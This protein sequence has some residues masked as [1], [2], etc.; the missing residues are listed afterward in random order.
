MGAILLFSGYGEAIEIKEA[1]FGFNEVRY[2]GGNKEA[3]NKIALTFDDAPNGATGDILRILKERKIKAT[4]F[5][6]GSQ[7]KKYP[8]MAR[9]IV[10]QGHEIGN[11]SYSH[12][13]D[14]SFTLEAILEDLKR[15]EDVIRDVTG[16]IPSY[17]R[18]P[19]GFTNG[20]IKE[21]CGIM[22]YS[23]IMWWVDSRDW[24]HEEQKIIDEV[25]MHLRPGGIV[26]LHSLPQT[27]RVLSQMIQGLEEK[28]YT[29]VTISDLLEG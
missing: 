14:E 17:F 6:I 10:D 1:V 9:A 29:L 22:G 11:H 12:Q 19:R 20:K 24:Q 8:D 4:F 21:A 18:P 26:L 3:G 5:L 23:I 15:A 7:V 16:L 27:A 25:Y 28:G 2:L 13:I